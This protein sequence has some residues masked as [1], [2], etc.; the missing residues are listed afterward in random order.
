MNINGLSANAGLSLVL[1][2][3]RQDLSQ[4]EHGGIVVEYDERN[5]ETTRRTPSLGDALRLMSLASRD[6]FKGSSR[7]DS[8]SMTPAGRHS[9]PTGD[10]ASQTVKVSDPIRKHARKA[11]RALA[12]AQALIAVAKSETIKA[13][14]ENDLTD[15]EIGCRVHAAAGLFAEPVRGDRC[16]W[17]YRFWLDHDD[18][19][20]PPELIVI[21]ETRG[22]VND[23]QVKEALLAVRPKPKKRVG[24]A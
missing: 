23:R 5:R 4:I 24:A 16:A 21:K 2:N 3:L 1:Q 22:K 11:L 8:A 20:A 17:C 12:D 15:G 7:Y 10:L 18:V 19:D 14:E 9:D 6:G 13:F